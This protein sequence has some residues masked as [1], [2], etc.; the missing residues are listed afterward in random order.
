M[1]FVLP[2]SFF[3][4]DRVN[5]NGNGMMIKQLA[6]R[7]PSSPKHVFVCSD[8]LSESYVFSLDQNHVS[9]DKSEKIQV[10]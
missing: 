6:S 8:M 3:I 4:Y 5:L 10:N 7:L 1:I 9:D 2:K